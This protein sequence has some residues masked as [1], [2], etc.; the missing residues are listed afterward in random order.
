MTLR[1]NWDL[2]IAK[3]ADEGACRACGRS[4]RKLDCAHVVGRRADVRS[5]NTAIVNPDSII[6][7]CGPST[8]TAS[9]HC[10]Y[11]QHRLDVC[12]LLSLDES[13]QAV[14]D[15]GGLG[16]AYRRVTGQRLE[17]AA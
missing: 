3:I 12:G 17:D 10:R 16:A 8:D 15:A 5:G 14:R 7:L 6:P 1:R 4:D 13:V 11:D 9:C 2:A